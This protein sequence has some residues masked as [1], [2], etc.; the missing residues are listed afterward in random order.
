MKQNSRHFRML[1]A[2][3]DVARA[4]ASMSEAPYR[5]G[6]FATISFPV[7]SRDE[8]PKFDN[9]PLISQIVQ[10]R[11]SALLLCAGWS[12]A[13]Q[14]GIDQIRKAIGNLAT[15]VIAETTDT[16]EKEIYRIDKKGCHAMGG[17]CFYKSSDRSIGKVRDLLD[18]LVSGKRIFEV[19][20]GSAALF[21]CGENAILSCVP[22][23]KGERRDKVG[24]HKNVDKNMKEIIR[25]SRIILHPTHTILPFA[26][27]QKLKRRFFSDRRLYISSSNW[28][29]DRAPKDWNSLH[30]VMRNGTVLSPTFCENSELMSYREWSFEGASS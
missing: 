26:G 3:R 4:V 2:E 14:G 25:N 27:I 28:E 8:G 10:K 9:A 19:A 13:N 15:T 23:Q 6:T 30:T 20:G 29:I 22:A 5:P 12:V 17:Q 1:Q 21:M 24:Y 18:L 16:E 11:P 7:L